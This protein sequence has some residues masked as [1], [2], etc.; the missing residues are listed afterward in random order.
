MGSLQ[1][2][3]KEFTAYLFANIKLKRYNRWQE[4]GTGGTKTRFH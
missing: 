3:V 2:T 4:N 1:I